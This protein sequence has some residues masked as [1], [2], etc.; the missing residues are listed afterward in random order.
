MSDRIAFKK[1]RISAYE[2]MRDY[3]KC[4]EL[5]EEITILKQQRRQLQVELKTIHKSN[6]QSKWYTKGKR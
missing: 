3:K 2:N 5:K 1:K 4:D 6:Y